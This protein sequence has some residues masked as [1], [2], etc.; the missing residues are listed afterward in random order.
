MAAFSCSQRDFQ[1]EREE[2]SLSASLNLLS[3]PYRGCMS[4]THK[5]CEVKTDSDLGLNGC[6]L[7]T[8]PTTFFLCTFEL[9]F[10]FNHDL[11]FCHKCQLSLR[12]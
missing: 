8:D 2:R 7:L 11:L 10:C 5:L 9:N 4:N 12:S 6:L 1:G 3:T